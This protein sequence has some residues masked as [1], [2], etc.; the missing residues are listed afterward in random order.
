MGI[1]IRATQD[2]QIKI[3]GTDITLNEVYMRI[4]FAARANGITLEIAPTTFASKQTYSENKPLYTD[5]ITSNLLL[6]LQPNETQT[7]DNALNYT[8]M[9]Y[10]QLG[11]DVVIDTL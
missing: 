2:K 3:S 4:E 10:T 1:F 6:D 8:A 7:I 5:V 9:F 11:Y